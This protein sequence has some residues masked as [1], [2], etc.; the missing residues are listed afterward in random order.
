VPVFNV[1]NYK[2]TDIATAVKAILYEREKAV[3]RYIQRIK[4]SRS[5]AI[6]FIILKIYL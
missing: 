3:I 2:V 1:I 5:F 4:T 6:I